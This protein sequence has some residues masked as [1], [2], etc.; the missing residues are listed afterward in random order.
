MLSYEKIGE[1]LIYFGVS[2]ILKFKSE[3]LKNGFSENIILLQTINEFN[4]TEE[5]IEELLKSTS[6]Y[7]KTI[8]GFL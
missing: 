4:W 8:G 5:S 2:L 6:V 3:L 1:F 7:F